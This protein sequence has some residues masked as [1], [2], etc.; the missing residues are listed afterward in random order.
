MAV[1]KT[2][3]TPRKNSFIKETETV[4]NNSD[5]ETVKMVEANEATEETEDTRIVTSKKTIKKFNPDDM[6]LCQSTCTG[7]TFF[8]GFKSGTIYTF[9]AL[10][11]EEY[12]EYKDLVA[13]VRSK[14][15]MIFK[16]FFIVLDEDFI[17][18]QKTLKKFY[19]SMYTPE[20]FE[21]FFR[22]NPNQM[23]E[24]LNNMPAGI[25]DTIKSMAV[26]KIQDGT[27]DSVARIKALDNYFGTKMMLLTELYGNN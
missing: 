5:T 12:I 7:Q 17:E 10:G 11:A 22:L 14:D 23:V 20:D 2:T 24:A 8:K 21:E 6:I 9:E 16:P 3:T 18:E 25:R 19:E 1:K 26:G 13:A 15:N 27:F 4:V